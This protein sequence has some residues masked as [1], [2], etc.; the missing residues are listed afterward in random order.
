TEAGSFPPTSLEPSVVRRASAR[1]LMT[2]RAASCGVLGVGTT[3]S[4][5]DTTLHSSAVAGR[6]SS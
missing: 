1:L 6:P 5:S 3:R 4:L 2:P